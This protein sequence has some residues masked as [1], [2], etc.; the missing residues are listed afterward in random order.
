[1]SGRKHDGIPEVDDRCWRDLGDFEATETSSTERTYQLGACR[2]V[3]TRTT[4]LRSISKKTVSCLIYFFERS[5][6]NARR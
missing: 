3:P 6:A 2:L 4:H 1:M 5:V